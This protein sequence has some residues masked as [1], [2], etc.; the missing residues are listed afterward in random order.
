MFA[1]LAAHPKV[2][3][4]EIVFLPIRYFSGRILLGYAPTES[5]DSDSDSFNFPPYGKEDKEREGLGHREGKAIRTLKKFLI[6]KIPK[7][8]L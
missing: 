6:L 5:T 7:K 3:I 4:F 2:F 1:E 8:L